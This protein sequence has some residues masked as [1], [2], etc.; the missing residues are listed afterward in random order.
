MIAQS[1]GIVGVRGAMHCRQQIS[2][3]R[4]AECHQARYV[5]SYACCGVG[6]CVEHDIAHDRGD[7]LRDR[8][9]HQAVHFL[10]DHEAR[11]AGRVKL[12]DDLSMCVP[13]FPLQGRKV[14]IWRLL[15][16][17]RCRRRVRP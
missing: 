15:N 4:N 11:G 7:H 13:Q 2:G 14:S 8:L 1:R 10:R 3:R 17:T 16:H 5:M 9:A 6:E 12:D